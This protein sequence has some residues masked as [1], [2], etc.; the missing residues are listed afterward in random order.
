[1]QGVLCRDVL[2]HEYFHSYQKRNFKAASVK[3]QIRPG[4]TSEQAAAAYIEQLLLSK[5]L[6]ASGPEWKEYARKF[7]AL[8]LFRRQLPD[9][10]SFNTLEDSLEAL[11]GSAVYF[12]LRTRDFDLG[13]S[14]PHPLAAKEK[15]PSQADLH[16]AGELL[17]SEFTPDRLLYW[18]QY[19]T[20]AAQGLLL[21][22]AG[23][24]WKS[25]VQD[26]RYMFN[27]FSVVFDVPIEERAGIVKIV[28]SEYG[29]TSLLSAAGRIMPG[30]AGPFADNDYAGRI[31]VRTCGKAS[32]KTG[33]PLG[34]GK[35]KRFIDGSSG[36]L[37]NGFEL[38]QRDF[39]R[40]KSDNP[41]VL[42]EKH[43]F[44]SGKEC[45]ETEISVLFP[46]SRL[47]IDK[48]GCTS[49]SQGFECKDLAFYGLNSAAHFYRSVKL[50]RQGKTI[51]LDV[52]P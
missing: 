12:E 46:L 38:E 24:D 32:I 21:D 35:L 51:F 9:P 50:S 48:T 28:K 49:D 20:G 10:Y 17:M 18:R 7:C 19:N 8:R 36:R 33:P 23:A 4:L 37:Y 43:Y 29:Y 25:A 47:S 45:L 13:A 52:Q 41:T 31:V 15:S 5:A 30:V 40:F 26:G 34:N 39:F 14:A 6:S 2:F 42:S 27:V 44:S 3:R 22:R 1:M 16:I 11:E